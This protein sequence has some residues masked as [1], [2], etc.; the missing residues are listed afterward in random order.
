MQSRNLRQQTH[1]LARPARPG[2]DQA[3]HRADLSVDRGAGEEGAVREVAPDKPGSGRQIY[4]N[5]RINPPSRAPDFGGR[6]SAH[7]CSWAREF[8][9]KK[10]RKRR[11]SSL[12]FGTLF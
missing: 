2:A 5:G 10:W 9:L 7:A 11:T 8:D 1:L 12:P 3:G 4:D 6:D